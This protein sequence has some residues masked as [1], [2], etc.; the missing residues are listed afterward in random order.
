MTYTPQVSPTMTCRVNTNLVGVTIRTVTYQVSR[1][2]LPTKRT[3]SMLLQHCMF[4]PPMS[5][6]F[7]LLVELELEKHNKCR[8]FQQVLSLNQERLQVGKV[9]I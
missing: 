1:P 8:L 5:Y 4:H 2:S 6:V 7:A 9:L 3:C